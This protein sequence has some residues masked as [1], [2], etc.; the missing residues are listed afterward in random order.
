M[1]NQIQASCAYNG[2]DFALVEEATAVQVAGSAL[3]LWDTL[4]R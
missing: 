1:T 3:I 4:T 2:F